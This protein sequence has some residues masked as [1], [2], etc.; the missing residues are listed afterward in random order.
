MIALGLSLRFSILG[1][2]IVSGFHIRVAL[3]TVYLG[4]GM[5]PFAAVEEL[6]VDD[7]LEWQWQKK[8][9]IVFTLRRISS[10]I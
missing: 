4:N 9:E 2:A 10:F 8:G 5:E 3:S 7:S 1:L 6:E